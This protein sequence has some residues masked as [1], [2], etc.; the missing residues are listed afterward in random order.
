[1]NV[2]L[3]P[4]SLIIKKKLWQKIFEPILGLFKIGLI[5]S[6]LLY[7]KQQN[8]NLFQK[9]FK[10][11]AVQKIPQNIRKNRVNFV[12]FLKICFMFGFLFSRFEDT[13]F[14]VKQIMLWKFKKLN[15]ESSAE[16]QNL[17]VKV[18]SMLDLDLKNGVNSF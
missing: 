7:S 6:I 10:V 16:V 18:H 4:K 8:Q 17:T 9:M 13:D 15:F 1:M 11:K 14:F 2:H 5:L 3:F 12:I